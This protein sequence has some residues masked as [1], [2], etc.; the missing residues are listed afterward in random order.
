VLHVIHYPVFGGP[1]N[2][3]L[4]LDGPLKQRGVEQLVL[5]P[6]GSDSATARLQN[7]AVEVV[8][9]PLSRV[10]ATG[11]PRPHVNLAR[12]LRRDVN[13][14]CQLIDERRVDLVQIAGLV[15][16]HAAFAARNRRI[17]IVWKLLDTRAPWLVAAIAMIFVRQLADSVLSTGAKILTAH[18][19]ALSLADR[20]VYYLPPVD[21]GRFSPSKQ[22]QAIVKAEWGVPEALVIGTVANI[23]PQKGID[24]LIDAYALVRQRRPAARLVLLGAESHAHRAYSSRL[25]AQLSRNGLLIG[26]DVFFLGARN[27]VYRQLPGFDVFVL[28]SVPRSEGIPTAILEAMA[29]GIPVV[30]T[31]VGGVSEIVEHETTGYVVRPLDPRSMA[32][33]IL[34]ATSDESARFALGSHARQAAEERF[35]T[36]GCVE[37]HLRAYSLALKRSKSDGLRPDGNA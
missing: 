3:A 15:N 12:N 19:G 34:R 7:A 14:I 4:V 32:D 22:L 2:E 11:D 24:T 27:D 9:L 21:L 6:E 13:A 30:A 8:T 18:P 29:C 35:G 26:R 28:A 23:N 17:P 25:R 36:D 1:H 5:L 16:P 37:A 33:A 10:R 20:V 31:D